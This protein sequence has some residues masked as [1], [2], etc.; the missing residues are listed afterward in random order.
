[1]GL[2]MLSRRGG[3]GGRVFDV[4][5]LPVAGAFD[6]CVLWPCGSGH[7]TFVS[8]LGYT[9]MQEHQNGD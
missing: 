9:G 8:G 1:M 7:L 3:G 5:S 2:S 4:R 6:H